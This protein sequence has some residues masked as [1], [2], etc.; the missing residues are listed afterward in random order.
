MRS[1][2]MVHVPKTGGRY[3]V[4][5]ALKHELIEWKRLP[6]G[7]LYRGHETGRF[8]YG[9]HNV[10]HS[11]PKSPI[12][13]FVDHCP[14]DPEFQSSLTFS[15][16][17]NP[18]D[19]LVSMFTARWPYQPQIHPLVFDDFGDFVRAYC[20]PEFEW[21]V[22]LQKQNLFFQ[23]ADDDGSCAVDRLLR[24]EALDDELAA[25][26][27]P[28]GITPVRSDPFRPS[29]HGE[30]RGYRRWYTDELRELVQTKC[31]AELDQFG[32]DFDGVTADLDPASIRIELQIE[33]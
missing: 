10:C 22:P 5:R 7:G 19:L 32:Y 4:V 11:D 33:R 21:A 12:Q 25:M 28:L 31:A 14:G 9:G 27:E 18:F 26:C 23:L 17:R 24:L 13:Y 16:V 6:P 29:R 8:Y 20:D 30:D 1:L 2:Y 3:V 15:V